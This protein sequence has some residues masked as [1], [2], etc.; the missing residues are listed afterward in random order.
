MSDQELAL[1][2]LSF[3]IIGLIIGAI[4]VYYSLHT[5]YEYQQARINIKNEKKYKKKE[6]LG[7]NDISRK[8]V[9]IYNQLDDLT[10]RV[11]KH[12]AI[13][14][15]QEVLSKQIEALRTAQNKRVKK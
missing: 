4:A 11:N 2:L 5:D 9:T 14:N 3:L 10:S 6:E 13:I 8:L 12:E 1:S 15:S 7:I